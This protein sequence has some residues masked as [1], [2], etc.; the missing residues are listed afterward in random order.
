[1]AIDLQ[2]IPNIS[3]PVIFSVR[4]AADDDDIML[5]QRLYILLLSDNTGQYRAS[6]D[7]PTFMAMLEGGNVPN[8]TTINLWLDIACKGVLSLLAAEDRA[9]ISQLTGSSDDGETIK[10]TLILNNGNVL[11]GTVSYA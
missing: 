1:M 4:T 9:R 8:I 7:F 2:I 5:L 6:G 10:L 3:G 11:T